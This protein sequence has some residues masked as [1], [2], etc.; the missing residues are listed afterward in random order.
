LFAW[1]ALLFSIS[2]FLDDIS[3]HCHPSTTRCLFLPRQK[4][5]FRRSLQ[6]FLGCLAAMAPPL[7]HVN[8]F[9]GK[10]APR[11]L[12]MVFFPAQR[13][14]FS[15]EDML[16]PFRTEPFFWTNHGLFC[17]FLWWNL[18]YFAD[19]WPISWPG[20]RAPT[21]PLRDVGDLPYRNLGFFFSGP[22]Q[23]GYGS[24]L[25]FGLSFPGNSTFALLPLLS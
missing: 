21:S 6:V 24:F 2:L 7:V 12:G 14:P 5:F 1:Q 18:F 10:T 3:L 20:R 4:T 9:P 11:F 23:E 8:L 17:F 16:A 22:D 25:P 19:G 15:L 13:F